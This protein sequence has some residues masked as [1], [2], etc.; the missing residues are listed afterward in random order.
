M[1]GVSNAMLG[2]FLKLVVA[3]S[4][5]I[6]LS[7]YAS[8]KTTS[9]DSLHSAP[10]FVLKVGG[11]FNANKFRELENTFSGILSAEVSLSPRISLQS[12]I[13][14]PGNNGAQAI[15][16]QFFLAGRYYFPGTNLNEERHTFNGLYL[17][18]AFYFLGQINQEDY[19]RYQDFRSPLA[20]QA[21]EVNYGFGIKIGKQIHGIFDYGIFAGAE[22]SVYKVQT[23][24]KEYFQTAVRSY[25]QINSYVRFH[26]PLAAPGGR[27]YDNLTQSFKSIE[28]PRHLLK[29]GLNDVMNL[30]AKGLFFNPNIGYEQALG[31]KG[32]SINLLLQGNVHR[33]RHFDSFNNSTPVFSE[34][35]YLTQTLAFAAETQLRV[36]ILRLP[37]KYNFESGKS[38]LEGFYLNTAFSFFTGSSET[39]RVFWEFVDYT[40]AAAGAGMGFQKLLVDQ[41]ILDAHLNYTEGMNPKTNGGNSEGLTGGLRFYWVW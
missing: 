13:E 14:I 12:G 26:L 17:S 15:E 8:E 7:T 16:G 20:E 24:D 11:Y 35:S 21:Y 1:S 38:V 33:F 22:R 25:P 30:S 40:G 5:S 29:L 18:P 36:Y 32:L 19:T 34:Q 9:R 4:F 2:R 39:K 28:N 3:L 10:Q 37:N 27:L 41:F 31:K 6:C 23:L